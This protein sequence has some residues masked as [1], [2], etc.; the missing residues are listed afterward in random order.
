MAYVIINNDFHV[1]YLEEHGYPFKSQPSL[2]LGKDGDTIKF[3]HGH[4]VTLFSILGPDTCEYLCWTLSDDIGE[5]KS[6]L[7]EI[8]SSRVK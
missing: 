5:K 4:N 7:W 8:L 3:L 1:K 2:A 6:K